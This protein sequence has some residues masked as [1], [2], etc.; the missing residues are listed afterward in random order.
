MRFY[1]QMCRHPFAGWYSIGGVIVGNRRISLALTRHLFK[2]HRDNAK[3]WS[4]FFLGLR[5]HVLHT[6][7][8]S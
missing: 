6:E 1:K 3:S 8:K 2:F 4:I 5:M 7:S